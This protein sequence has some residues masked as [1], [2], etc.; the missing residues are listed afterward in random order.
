MQSRGR[1]VC[2]AE[3]S[4]RRQAEP[5]AAVLAA[6]PA[7]VSVRGAGFPG[8]DLPSGLLCAGRSA[9]VSGAVPDSVP[10]L[11]C[12][13]GLYDAVS[14]AEGPRRLLPVHGVY[15]SDLHHCH[16]HLHDLSHLSEPARGDPCAGQCADPDHGLPLYLR[17]QYEC[18][19]VHP[20]AGRD[21]HA[22]CRAADGMLPPSGPEAALGAPDGADLPVHGVPQAAFRP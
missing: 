8:G 10:A 6:V 2:P 4:R 1:A 21:G 9:P 20:C 11:V 7:D 5:A 13:A 16:V 19:P 15:D 18:L 12:G 22:V 3:G 14:A 17:Y